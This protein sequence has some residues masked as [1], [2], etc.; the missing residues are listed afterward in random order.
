MRKSCQLIYVDVDVIKWLLGSK[1]S[2]TIFFS[3][4]KIWKKKDDK[5]TNIYTTSP[6]AF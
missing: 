6:D 1:L 2:H 5:K 4:K 3:A